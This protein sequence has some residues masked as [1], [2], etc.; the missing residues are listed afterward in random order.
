MKKLPQI[1][2]SLGVILIA[3]SVILLIWI[4]LPVL[5]VE[6]NYGLNKPHQGITAI[7]PVDQNFDIIIPKIGANAKIIPNVDPYNPM[8]YQFALTR[9]VAQAKG[10]STPD[11]IGNIF[12]FSHSSANLLEATRYNSVFYLLSKLNK[13]DE[14]YIY[15]K[16][17]KYK[18]LVSDTKLAD[19]KDV[20]YLNLKSDIRSL[21]LMTCWPAGT[22]FQR[23]LVFAIQK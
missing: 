19:S 8:T 5:S 7:K 3:I 2:I 18:Y 14:I 15:Y 4:F 22:D 13:N 17:V 23:L 10:T 9:G 11:V 21:T 16:H 1:L 12:L 6:V 20:S